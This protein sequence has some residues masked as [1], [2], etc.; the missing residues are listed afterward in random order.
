M[1]QSAVPR[2][3]L[4]GLPLSFLLLLAVAPLFRLLAEGGL[5]FNPSLLA[6]DYLRWR[7]LWSLIQASASCLLCLVLACR[8]PGCW[9]VTA[10]PDAR[11]CCAC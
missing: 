5:Q 2:L 9:P 10:F 7:L 11:C 8:W 4:A 3:I 6:D 1:K